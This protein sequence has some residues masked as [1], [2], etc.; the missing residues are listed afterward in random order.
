MNELKVKG[1]PFIKW[2]GGKGQ[3]LPQ[4]ENAL[5]EKLYT[6]EFIYIEPFVGGGAML[7]F[8]LQHF[9]NIKHVVINDINSNLTKAYQIIKEN[10]DELVEKLSAKFGRESVEAAFEGRNTDISL[11]LSY[12][13]ELN[14]YNGVKSIQMKIQGIL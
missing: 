9:P 14:E 2:V 3:L 10:P 11:V 1:K 13:P 12:I 5:P 6:E 4:L 8:M 7:F